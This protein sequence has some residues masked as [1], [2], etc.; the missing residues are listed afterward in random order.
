MVTRLF[1]KSAQNY[2]YS[3]DLH[4]QP[5]TPAAVHGHLLLARLQTGE[6]DTDMA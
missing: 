1:L 6:G 3:K 2:Y 5:E 4:R